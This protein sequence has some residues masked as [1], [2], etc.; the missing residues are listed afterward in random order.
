[1]RIRYFLTVAVWA[2]AAC[3]TAPTVRPDPTPAQTP[4]PLSRLAMSAAA[5]ASGL[6]VEVLLEETRHRFHPDGTKT[7]TARVTFRVLNLRALDEWGQV[8]TTFRPWFEARPELSAKVTTPD[9]EVFNLDPATVAEAPVA[10]GDG[11]LLSDAR[12]V[13]A[14]LPGLVVGALVEQVIVKRQKKPFFAEGASGRFYFGMGVPV[15][16]SRLVLEVPDEVALT[17]EVRGL[18]LEPEIQQSD[19]IRALTFET[20]PMVPQGGPTLFMPSDAPRFPY[21]AFST[22]PDWGRVARRYAELVESRLDGFDARPLVAGIDPTL[23]RPTVLAKLVSRL[24]ET[25]RY[26]G[27]EFGEQS[28]V[29]WKP[30]VTLARRFGDCKDKGTVLIAML[31]AVGL[32]GHL[33]LLHSGFGEDIRPELPGL[34]PFN[35]AIVYVPGEPGLWIDATA[36]F[37]PIGQLPSSVQGRLAL[38]ASRETDEL[39]PIPE[40]PAKANRYLETR[41]I[42]LS[43]WGPV[44]IVERTLA[45]G[46]MER[47]LRAQFADSSEGQ[48][49]DALE[50]YVRS[51]YKAE[52]LSAFQMSDP[53]DLDVPFEI[54]I[55]AGQAG[56]GFTSSDE[57]G[58]RLTNAIVFSWLPKPVRLAALARGPEDRDPERRRAHRDLADRTADF[59]WPEPYQAEVTF[60]VRPPQGYALRQLPK[61]RRLALGPGFFEATYRRRDDGR[62]DAE[63]IFGVDRRRYSADELRQF[64]AGLAKLWNEQVPTLR[65]DHEGARLLGQGKLKEGIQSYRRLARLNA[66]SALHQ[67]R[68]AEALLKI[69]LGQAARAAAAKA[70]ALEPDSPYAHYTRAWVLQHDE[71]GRAYEPGFERDDAVAGYR[72]V[73]ELQ[74]DNTLAMRNLAQ[75]LQY[76]REGRRYAH[77]EGL[78]ASIGAYRQLRKRTEGDESVDEAL[79]MALFRAD[80]CAEVSVL[81]RDT[82]RSLMRDGLE[83]TCAILLRGL[84]DGLRQVEE[85]GLPPEARQAVLE[86]SVR[87]LVTA[88]AYPEARELALIAIPGSSDPVALESQVRTLGRLKRFEAVRLPAD[89][90]ARVV[91][92][93]Y[94]AMFDHRGDVDG[95]AEFFA[96]ASLQP[97]HVDPLKDSLRR[98]LSMLARM[99]TG[100]MPFLLLRD[101]V[102]S[103]TSFTTEGSDALGYRIEARVNGG[104]GVS[105]VWF[106][107]KERGRY[108]I[109]CGSASG[110]LIGSEALVRAKKRRW[111]QAAQWLDWARE[112]W[113]E[114]DE[115]DGPNIPFT[116]V[117]PPPKGQKARARRIRLAAMTLAAAGPGDPGL[118]RGLERARQ[119]LKGNEPLLI[120]LDSAAFM[121]VDELDDKAGRLKVAR[122]MWQ[123]QPGVELA[124]VFWVRA[125][126]K[127]GRF[128]A[129]K[130]V[131]EKRRVSQPDDDGTSLELLADLAV[132]QSDFGTARRLLRQAIDAGKGSARTYNNL[133]W[134][135]LFGSQVNDDDLSLALRA[136]SLS[137][138]K[139]AGQLHTLAAVYAETGRAR[140]ALQLIVKRLDLLGESRLTNVD[141]YLIGR[142]HEYF[143]LYDLAKRAYERVELEP[144]ERDADSTR[145]LARRRL[146]TLGR[147]PN[148]QI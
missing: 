100:E 67:A 133:V 76:D 95:L 107:I 37:V 27:V 73:L 148:Q 30:E 61:S 146:R 110:W 17:H 23:P 53:T 128:D 10:N 122:R 123:A 89:E 12:R 105:T 20:G 7:E 108:K 29:P 82:E 139:N 43:D 70:V 143:E 132:R 64:V 102:M 91:Q 68:L 125:L 1:M 93:L 58:V 94:E 46:S 6:P 11:L 141:W 90:P 114:P 98:E 135:R 118:V 60:E 44:D 129:A 138:F 130:A 14:P 131:I 72:R 112:L 142:L 66:N 86:A 127:A 74:D 140:E 45:F 24:H 97:P 85:M 81:A 41:T 77:R 124:Y 71:L 54:E 32:D 111:G 80:R 31:R 16:V 99:Q 117:W 21:V 120:A 25:I 83:V 4:E 88:R 69:K 116:K 40:A 38:V 121:Q 9:G 101:S 136:N 109:R 50:K 145:A 103:L 3:Q 137:S 35:H 22:I 56:I 126:T 26:T 5:V 106:V 28:I 13:I 33:A 19:G 39:Q 113:P 55:R 34:E 84:T 48:V 15:F 59:V 147:R 36:P 57:A 65:F 51:S 144:G 115:A 78:E 52:S 119:G 62:I 42:T 18:K 87:F 47:R 92:K 49:R 2:L 96:E 79:L 75:V 134:L 63:F 104:P 8:S